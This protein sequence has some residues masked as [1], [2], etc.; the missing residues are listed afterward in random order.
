MKF[1]RLLFKKNVGILSVLHAPKQITFSFQ[2]I[3]YFSSVAKF[4]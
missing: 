4:L 1:E 3:C 2:F